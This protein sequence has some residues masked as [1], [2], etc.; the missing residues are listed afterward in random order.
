MDTVT[1]QFST[2]DAWQSALIRR[3]C[4]SPFS[5]VDL[6]LPDGN[7]LGASDSPDAPV[8]SGNSHGV[9]IRPSNYQEFATRRRMIIETAKA[10]A[11]TAAAVLQLGKPFDGDALY[12]F[13][14]SADPLT[15][16]RDWRDPGKWFC[17][18]LV[19]AAFETGGHWL[20]EPLV[21]PLTRVSPT[22]LLL[23]FLWDRGFVNRREFW[24]P[25]PGLVLDSNER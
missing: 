17:A 8:V 9:A 18:E 19:A 16:D 4:H 7:M 22:D 10:D 3:V 11:I 13:L 15:F 2:T 1:L 14:G 12:A 5:H 20:P 24:Q 23:M 25:V 6:V 21:W